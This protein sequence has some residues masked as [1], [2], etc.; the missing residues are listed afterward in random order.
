MRLPFIGIL[1][2]RSD[3]PK[4][5]IEPLPWH[6]TRQCQFLKVGVLNDI[7]LEG[8]HDQ[9]P[10]SSP[11]GAGEDCDTTNLANCGRVLVKACGPDALVSGGVECYPMQAFRVD[12]GLSMEKTRQGG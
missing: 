6:L 4:L 11:A 2:S 1:V 7:L 10:K 3:I 5:F 9:T 8:L 12:P